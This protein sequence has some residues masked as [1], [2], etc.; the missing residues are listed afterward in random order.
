MISSTGG[1][2]STSSSTSSMSPPQAVTHALKPSLSSTKIHQ[3]Q[4]QQAASTTGESSSLSSS[5]L[6]PKPAATTTTNLIDLNDIY[7]YFPEMCTH[8]LN[9]VQ[10]FTQMCSKLFQLEETIQTQKQVLSNLEYDLQRELN[11][12][13]T[14][15]ATTTTTSASHHQPNTT[16]TCM[17]PVPPACMLSASAETPETAE[18]R[19]EVTLSR[20]QTRLQCKQLHDLD[21][22]IR[23]NE[24]SL[25]MRE[26]QL[27]QLLEELYIQEIY[28]DNALEKA[29]TCCSHEQQQQQQLLQGNGQMHHHHHHH[30][31]L[32][33]GAQTP[34]N[35]PNFSTN[36]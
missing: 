2:T 30:H 26:Q 19:K 3:Q 27:Q 21:A 10:D 14:T 6:A 11:P 35:L 31:M 36:G 18:L 17:S 33:G 29:L 12:T 1:S 20:E 13:T 15:T 28:A 7:C 24:H 23:T 16:A 25:M 22:K 8:Q 34:T 9:E 4:Q 32:L 5:A